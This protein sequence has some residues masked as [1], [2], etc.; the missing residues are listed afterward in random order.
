MILV[1]P[2]LSE[3]IRKG[4]EEWAGEDHSSKFIAF[5]LKLLAIQAEVEERAVI[6][7]YK[8]ERKEIEEMLR[9]GKHIFRVED[10]KF[11]RASV[12]DTFRKIAGLFGENPD[13]LGPVP[14]SILSSDFQLSDEM[15]YG[16]LDKD[17]L[18]QEING[19][20]I[21]PVL[22]GTI[23]QQ[24]LRPF[25]I[26]FNRALDAKY[27]P[28]IWR[29]NYCPVCGSEADFSF[30]EKEVGGRFLVCPTCCAEWQ[31]QRTR[32]PYCGNAE[33][34]KLSFLTDDSG[35]YRLYLCEECKRYLK[36]IDLRKTADQ[37][38]PALESLTTI[39]LDRQAREKGYHPGDGIK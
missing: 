21:D 7:S 28:E 13:I 9:Q 33:P 22:L 18:P 38:I 39:A 23:L 36:A 1:A 2:N 17:E 34:G 35:L 12:N 26:G 15:I 11:D 25:L 6:P 20:I 8:I 37:K 10:H 32:C 5:Y 19:E 3:Q 24:T 4:L 30:L 31:F 14:G 29:R 16:W 27:S